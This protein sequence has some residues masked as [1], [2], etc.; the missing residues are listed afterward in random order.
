MRP[1]LQLLA[2]PVLCLFPGCK[3]PQEKYQVMLDEVVA[4]HRAPTEERIAQLEAIRKAE[5]E[6]AAGGKGLPQIDEAPADRKGK[7]LILMAPDTIIRGEGKLEPA[8]RPRFVHDRTI[9]DLDRPGR[10]E[11][12]NDPDEYVREGMVKGFKEFLEPHYAVVCRQESLQGVTITDY[13]SNSDKPNE[14]YFQGGDF[15]GECRAFDIETAECLG[16]FP[17]MAN[18]HDSTDLGEAL[19]LELDKGIEPLG[20]RGSSMVD[21]PR[22]KDADDPGGR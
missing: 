12:G 11:H 13:K 15:I 1:R 8:C 22:A 7:A 3:S 6:L 17:L 19:T 20:H 5:A 10:W 18:L 16:G 14:L 21:C 2:L 4:E 9:V